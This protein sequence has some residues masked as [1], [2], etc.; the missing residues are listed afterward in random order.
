MLQDISFNKNF[1]KK[2]ECYMVFI[3]FNGEKRTVLL[4]THI[5]IF[6]DYVR[7]NGKHYFREGNVIWSLMVN[8]FVSAIK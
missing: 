3:G 7:V 1:G 4:I 8:I 6:T 5:I 2:P